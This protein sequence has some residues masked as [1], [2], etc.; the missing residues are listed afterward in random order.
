MSDLTDHEIRFLP[1]AEMQQLCGPEVNGYSS[2]RVELNGDPSQ[3]RFVLGS[4]ERS[5][6]SRNATTIKYIKDIV[7]RSPD[8]FAGIGSSVAS[9]SFIFQGDDRPGDAYSASWQRKKHYRNVCLVPDFYYVNNLG[10]ARFF[11]Q[12]VSAW[13]SRRLEFYWRGSTTGGFH[14]TTASLDELPRYKLCN[15]AKARRPLTNVAFYTVVQAA[16]DGSQQ[17]IEERLREEGLL[18]PF[19]D[20]GHYVDRKYIIQVDG[21][22]NSWELV[23]KLR[24]GCCLLI[25]DSDWQLWHDQFIKPWEHFIPIKRDFSDLNEIIDWCLAHDDE[26]RQIAENGR[27]YAMAIDFDQELREAAKLLAAHIVPRPE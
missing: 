7:T 13:N 9:A 11:D 12:G 20:M 27:A 18:L 3:L 23:R 10:Y 21:N 24:L 4:D 2:I 1:L 15:V 8:L 14:I 25:G 19:T 22:G 16:Q 26:A 17:E 6:H 5:V